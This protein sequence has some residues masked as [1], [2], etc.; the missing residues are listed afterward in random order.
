MEFNEIIAK[1]KVAGITNEELKEHKKQVDQQRREIVEELKH[2]RESSFKDHQ[3][4]IK[5]L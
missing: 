3:K 5:E 2:N 1:H 4:F